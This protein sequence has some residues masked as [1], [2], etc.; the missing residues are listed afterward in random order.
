ARNGRDPDDPAATELAGRDGLM[1]YHVA[2]FDHLLAGVDLS[3]VSVTLEAGAASLPAAAIVVALWRRRSISLDQARGAFNADPL[4]VLARDGELPLPAD[5]ALALM[6]E[7]AKWTAKQCPHV[8]AVRVGTAPYHHAGATAAQDV[9]F[10]M[11]TAVE[12]LRAI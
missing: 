4:A 9:A 3:R 6:A 11:A 5:A 8:T 2:D 7:L 10:S 12:Y 1:A